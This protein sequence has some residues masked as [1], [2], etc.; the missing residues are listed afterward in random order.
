MFALHPPV[1]AVV[2][3]ITCFVVCITGGAWVI[4]RFF[5]KFYV[6]IDKRCEKIALY[7][8]LAGLILKKTLKDKAYTYEFLISPQEHD[9]KSP[10]TIR[11]KLFRGYYLKILGDSSFLQLPGESMRNTVN[12]RFLSFG[13]SVT[14]IDGHKHAYCIKRI[15][16]HQYLQYLRTI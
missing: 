7:P 4:Y 14:I 15:T 10:C 9:G 2:L 13:Q 16:R 8:E 6:E 5:C 11:K 3:M 1:G 12:H